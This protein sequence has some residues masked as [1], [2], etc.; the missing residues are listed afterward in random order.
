MGLRTLLEYFLAGFRPSPGRAALRK[1]G[2]RPGLYH[3]FREASGQVGRFHLRVDPEGGGLLV[4]GATAAVWLR[5]SGV[6]YAKGLLEQLPE[7]KIFQLQ[8][9]AFGPVP[10]ERLKRDLAEVGQLLDRLQTPGTDYPMINLMDPAWSK[11]VKHLDRPLSADLPAAEPDRLEPI[12][13]RLWDL[14]IPHVTLV[15]RKTTEPAWLVRAVE[16][17]EDLGLIAGVRGLGSVLNKKNL[18]SDLAHAGVDHLN[19]LYLAEDQ[20]V[21]DRWTCAGDHQQALEALETAQ[22]LQICTVAEIPLFAPTWQQMDQT[23]ASLLR[24][25]VGNV[26]LY[27]IAVAPGIAPNAALPPDQLVQAAQWVEEAASSIQMRFLWYPPVQY[28]LGQ[29]LSTLLERG[30]RCSGDTAIRVEPDGSVLPARGPA[31]AAGNLLK[32][33]WQ[34]IVRSPV[35]RRYQARLRS[36]TRCPQCP[37]LVICAADCPRHPEGWAQ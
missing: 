18:L 1:A 19:L 3:Y 17:A 35:M 11:E 2:I 27:A 16:L 26:A 4:A 13:R 14:A 12:L 24:R 29:S 7:E 22:K 10:A 23:L 20:A 15:A 25:A 8:Q 6:I 32:D 5:P 9:R 37:G 30:P 21:H 34:K 28:H 31:Y 33:S 36:D